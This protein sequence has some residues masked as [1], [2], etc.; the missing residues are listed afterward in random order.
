MSKSQ[1]EQ[2]EYRSKSDKGVKPK[3]ELELDLNTSVLAQLEVI[4]KQLATTAIVLE[5]VSQVQPLRCNFHGEG[6]ANGNCVPEGVSVEAQ[7]QRAEI[8]SNIT[9]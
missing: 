2:N 1:H 4:S 6:Y 3:G 7:Y 8:T 5:N 9:K